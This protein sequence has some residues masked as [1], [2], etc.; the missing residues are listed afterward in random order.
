MRG[1]Y[2]SLLPTIS[3]KCCPKTSSH[4]SSTASSSLPPPPRHNTTLENRSATSS[5]FD[6]PKKTN[7]RVLNINC[8]SVAA[9][10]QELATALQ[11]TKPDIVC[12]TESWLRGIK[13]GK[14]P[15]PDHIKSSEVFPDYYEVHR[16]DRTTLGGGVFILTHKSLTAVEEPEYVTDCELE[17]V[18]VKLK[19]HRDL[20]IGAFYMPERRQQDLNELHRSLTKLTENGKKQRDVIIAGDFNCPDINWT[21]HT[22]HSYG[23]DNDVQQS[24]IDITSSFLLTQTHHSPTRG[25]NTLD[26]VFTSNPTL[27]KSSVSIPGVSDHNIVVTDFDTKPHVNRQKPRKCYKFGKAD[28][29]QMK[30][31]LDNTAQ[32]IAG[33][34]KEG[35]DAESLW[36][37]FKT[38]LFNSINKNIPSFMLKQSS[39]LPWITTPIKR[40]LKR[41]KRLF[42]RARSTN[43]WSPYRQFQKHCRR[44]LRRA[45]WRYI[46]GTIQ[47]GLDR[48]D[49]KPFWR[50]IKARKQDNT[51]VAPLKENGHLHSDSQSKADILL[52]QFKSVFTKDSTQPL[53]CPTP[54]S[55][56]IP[57]LTITTPG[58]TKLLKLL[59]PNKASG[60]DNIPNIVLKTLA[61]NIAPILQLIFQTSIDSGRLPKDWLTANVSCAFKKGDRHLASNYRPISLTSV[62]CKL[63]E[64]IICR[65]IMTHLQSNNILT[66]LNHGFRSGFSTE[67]QLLTTTNDLLTSFDQDTQVDMAILDFSKAFDTVPHDRL[68]HKLANYGIT[69]PIHNWLRCF[70]TERSMQVVVEGTSSE[71]TTVDSGVPQ[72]TVLGPLLFLCHINDLPEAVKSQVRLFADDCLIYREIRTFN[73]HYTL[74]A[75]LKSLEAWAEKW[76]MR[77]NASKCYIMS[78]AR[79]PASHFMYSL[80]DTILQNVRSNPYLGILFSNDMKWSNH[81]CNMT[82]KANSTLGFLRRNL[83]HC[84]TPCKKN[85]Y[86]ALVRPL[87]EYG[88]I[89]WDPYLKQDADKME[90]IQRNAVRFISRDY[91]STT[92]GFVTGLLKKYKLHTLQERRE[93]LRLT[94]FFKVVEGLVPAIPPDK[95]LIPQKPGR[96]IRP[97]TYQSTSHTNNPVENYIRNNDRCFAVPR[98]NTEQ[99][100]QSFFPRTIIAWNRLDDTVVHSDSVECFK[101]ALAAASSR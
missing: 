48:N 72:G 44:E 47:E 39:T 33:E 90:R 55:S 3:E 79:Q 74:Q 26:L 92:P 73:D 52:K 24:L 13:P 89:I 1:F 64:H 100:K 19:N 65:H 36:T 63:L 10:K 38:S 7:L 35:K 5:V 81:I 41:K 70:L 60:P 77:F 12:G 49:S 80:N 28:W 45:E 88:A 37:T 4:S 66:N 23:K 20:H 57:P 99:Y 8:Q 82:K 61:E 58:V 87:L 76:G 62:P 11:Y 71:S 83:R 21:T 75:D 91:R 16:N 22:S 101:S 93:Q 67:T 53:P 46:N 54:V 94:F 69:G 56:A 32:I 6:L 25:P 85:A 98:C 96:R 43:N 34:H 95:F 29:E 84:P 9:K 78:L 15:S 42:Q 2:T 86:L 27:V 31:D 51:G 30:S 59:Q 50:F 18:K 68:L 97:R 17:W 40:L 14:T